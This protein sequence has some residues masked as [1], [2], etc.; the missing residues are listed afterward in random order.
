MAGRTA[1]AGV[2]ID[3]PDGILITLYVMLARRPR[4]Y[5]RRQRRAGKLIAYRYDSC[6]DPLQTGVHS[7][8]PWR[9]RTPDGG[10]R[11]LRLDEFAG[12][13]SGEMFHLPPRCDWARCFGPRCGG[14][15]QSQ[16]GLVKTQNTWIPHERRLTLVW[17]S[18]KIER[19]NKGLNRS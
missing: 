11:R 6:G 17:R 3:A 5:R 15:T 12:A 14:A 8:F 13:M 9:C 19:G 16:Q 1:F 10:R 7:A 18:F 2:T 4:H